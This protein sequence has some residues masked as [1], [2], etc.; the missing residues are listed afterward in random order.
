MSLFLIEKMFKGHLN[1]LHCCVGSKQKLIVCVT[2]QM[3][4]HTLA[5]RAL[6]YAHMP[7]KVFVPPFRQGK[8]WS[9][10]RHVL[11]L[12]RHKIA[13]V[14]RQAFILPSLLDLSPLAHRRSASVFTILHT[15]Q[16]WYLHRG[17][18]GPVS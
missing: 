15:W 9:K 7:D 1:N 12:F 11:T 5:K 13:N 3:C 8:T 6:S 16:K 4:V 14:L 10:L 18:I 17:K 2:V